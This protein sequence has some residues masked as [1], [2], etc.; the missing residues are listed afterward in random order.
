MGGKVPHA[1]FHILASSAGAW[2]LSRAFSP[3]W[4]GWPSHRRRLK[5]GRMGASPWWQWRLWLQRVL[6]VTAGSSDSS[7]FV[8]APWHQQ[9]CGICGYRPPA[10]VGAALQ[11]KSRVCQL[12]GGTTSS[13][14]S[15]GTAP[16]SCW[17]QSHTTWFLFCSS[18]PSTTFLTGSLH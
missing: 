14:L 6:S 5:V 11:H 2:S 16:S 18:S 17:L 13:F 7:H 8:A 4:A 9:A 3:C 10:A 12:P 1:P 15:L